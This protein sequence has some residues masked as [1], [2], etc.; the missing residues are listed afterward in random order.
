MARQPLQVAVIELLC[1]TDTNSSSYS[2]F[3]RQFFGV[4]PQSIAAWC[5]RAGHT[6]AY[7]T[8]YGQRPVHE[9]IPSSAEVVFISAFTESCALAYC[10]ANLLRRRGVR[11]ILGGPHANAFPNDA[12]RFFDVVVKRCDETLIRECLEETYPRGAILNSVATTVD[13]PSLAERRADLD[14]VSLLF[15]SFSNLSVIPIVSSSGC[16]YDCDFCVDWDQQYRLRNADD[17]QQDFLYASTQMPGRTLAFYDPNFGVNFDKTVGVLEQL[18][19]KSRN[20]YIIES[21]LTVLKES[22]LARLRDTNCIFI[23]PGVE[24]WSGY[25]RKTGTMTL[26]ASAK[27]SRIVEHFALIGRY[28]PGLQANFLFGSDVDQGEEPVQLTR[29]FI[30]RFPNIFPGIAVPIAFGGIPMREALR[31]Q[32]RLLPLPACYYID[33]FPTYRFKHYA[34]KDF[35]R[36]LIAIYREAAGFKLAVRRMLQPINLPIRLSYLVRIFELR[37][38]IALLEQFSRVLTHDKEVAA[39]NNGKSA[40]IPVY[41]DWALSLRLGRYAELLPRPD[42][43]IATVD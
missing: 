32:Q 37:R 26:D 35:F 13:L 29:E 40:A 15:G 20:P 34:M 30:R 27:F 1:G 10:L 39:F 21:S 33:P 6:V 12:A 4:M 16:P 5:R 17:L 22:R 36:H 41:Y 42:R 3:R 28:V 23:A 24:A 7:S 25:G 31:Q 9:L 11:T 19:P 18:D 38:H 14:R 2:L 43:E 8:Y